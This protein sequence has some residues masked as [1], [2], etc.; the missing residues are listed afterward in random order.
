MRR[1]LFACALVAVASLAAACGS[2]GRALQPPDEHGTIAPRPSS[3]SS[4]TRAGGGPAAV[5]TLSSDLWTPGGALPDRFT[6]QGPDLSPPLSI[7]KVPEGAAELALVVS[8]PT[9]TSWIV[10]GI[11][12]ST[13]AIA[14]G[15]PPPGAAVAM[16]SGGK[17]GWTGPCDQPE[18]GTQTYE[19]AL[20]ALQSPSGVTEGM[21]TAEARAL[22]DTTP[23]MA[24]SLITGTYK[25]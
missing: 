25:A 12:A 7:A 21:P 9:T 24:T 14:E 18:A 22:I 2:S 11:P 5:F 23:I 17:V 3:G 19:F 6:C 4:T 8:S 10:A 20:Y 15:Q 16:S 13:T 1:R